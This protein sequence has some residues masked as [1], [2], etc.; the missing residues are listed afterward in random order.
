MAFVVAVGHLEVLQLAL[1][2]VVRQMVLFYLAHQNQY[3]NHL[4]VRMMNHRHRHLPKV[5]PHPHRF[6]HQE[7]SLDLV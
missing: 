5:S 6:P 2:I 7:A 4:R 1:V 3:L